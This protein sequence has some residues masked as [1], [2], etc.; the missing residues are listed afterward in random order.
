M[1]KEIK[2]QLKLRKQE[3]KKEY[4]IVLNYYS[5]NN[6][7]HKSVFYEGKEKGFYNGLGALIAIGVRRGNIAD[8]VCI[9]I[10]NIN[11]FIKNIKCL[12]KK[13]N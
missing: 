7:K 9:P 12:I 4:E 6:P 10:E 3:L 13:N 1:L 5:P 11:Q 8:V 2:R